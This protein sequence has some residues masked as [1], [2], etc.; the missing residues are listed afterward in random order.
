MALSK[1]FRE[2][3]RSRT[4]R[5]RR[6]QVALFFFWMGMGLLEAGRPLSFGTLGIRSLPY[7][8]VLGQ[9]FKVWEWQRSIP[10]S[11]LDDRSVL[12]HGVEFEGLREP[13]QKELLRRYQVGTYRMGYLPDEREGEQERRLHVQAYAVLRRLLPVIAVIYW[14]GWQ[15][16]PLGRMR[17]RWTDGPVVMTWVLLLVLA[18]PQMIRMWTEPDEVGEPRVVVIERET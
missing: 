1:E 13:E 16:L 6:V 5:W 14:V 3:M 15:L 7:I 8:W 18:L 9:I 11:S 17:D 12:E 2:A 10:V 4:R